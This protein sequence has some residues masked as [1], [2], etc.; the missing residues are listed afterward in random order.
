MRAEEASIR[1]SSVKGKGGRSSASFDRQ[2]LSKIIVTCHKN[3]F[4][5]PIQVKY[6]CKLLMNPGHTQDP[7]YRSHQESQIIPRLT[8]YTWLCSVI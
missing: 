3:G 7:D 2:K 6:S 5:L 1:S 8:D 4:I